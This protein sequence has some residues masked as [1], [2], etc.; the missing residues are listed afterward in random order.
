MTR[1]DAAQIFD[2]I[3][4]LLELKGENAFK[5]R[6]YRSGAEVVAGFAGDIMKMAAEGTL[7]GIKGLGD[8]LR[9]KLK[10][11]ATTGKLEFYERLKAEFP[12]TLFELFTVQG[13]GPK[14][15]AALFSDLGVASIEDL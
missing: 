12:E 3:A 11:M 6:A 14:K 2:R 7:T 1:E 5:V 15:I 8:A 13:L 9:D 4:V 10:E